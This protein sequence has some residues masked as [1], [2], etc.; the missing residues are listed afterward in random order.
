MAD[1]NP[2]QQNPNLQ[3]PEQEVKEEKTSFLTQ[4]QNTAKEKSKELKIQAEVYKDQ[5]QELIDQAQDYAVKHSKRFNKF[6]NNIP[7]NKP[8]YVLFG[9]ILIKILFLPNIF[10]TR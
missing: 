5:A 2:E 4:I 3:D 9:L 1:S 7:P 6:V 10:P 8:S